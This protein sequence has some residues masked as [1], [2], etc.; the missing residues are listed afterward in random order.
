MRRQKVRGC[1]KQD[2]QEVE[3]TRVAD[4][5]RIV[6]LP[7]ERKR[8]KQ[9]RERNPDGNQPKPLTKGDAF[10]ELSIGDTDGRGVS[11]TSELWRPRRNHKQPTT[12]PSKTEA[13]KPDTA[14]ERGGSPSAI[15]SPLLY[16]VLMLSHPTCRKEG[17]TTILGFI[18]WLT[19]SD[20]TSERK[21]FD[22]CRI[23][24][25]PWH[26]ADDSWRGKIRSLWAR[27]CCWA[28]AKAMATPPKQQTTNDYA[29]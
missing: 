6:V 10:H 15:C 2:R 8:Q 26:G 17:N 3:W 12:M 28:N 9:A 25:N 18:H 13:E 4:I 19:Y 23:T 1:I 22:S 11:R 16:P 29:E 24:W 14:S 21:E 7:H 5:P 20:G 27:L